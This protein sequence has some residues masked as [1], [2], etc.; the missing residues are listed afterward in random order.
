MY[1]YSLF[2]VFVYMLHPHLSVFV[3][4]FSNIPAAW[5]V[6]VLLAGVWHYWKKEIHIGYEMA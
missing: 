1:S 5:R 4:S 6:Y 3:F 2:L